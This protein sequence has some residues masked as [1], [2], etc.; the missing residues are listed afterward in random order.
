MKRF[1]Y[2]RADTPIQAATSASPKEAAFIAGGTNLLDLMKYEIETPIKLVDVTRLELEQIEPT[3]DGG[4]RIGTLVTNSDLAAHPDIVANYPVL[5]RAILAGATGQLRN[6]ATTGGNFLQRTRCYYFYQTDSPCNKRE[7]GTGCPAINGENRTLAILGTSEAC[8]AQHPSDMAVAMRL[9]DAK[10]ETVKTDG[11]TRTIPI[12]DFYC[13]PKDT[14]HIENVLESGELITHVVL[15]APIKG[16]HTYDKVR[17]RASYA[18]ALVSCAAVIDVDDSGKLTTIRLAFGGIG[19]EPWRNEKVEAL[20]TDTDGN[21]DVIRQAADL[22]LKEAKGNGQND[23]K[24]PLTRRLL[25]QVIQRAL[26][27]EGA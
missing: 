9:L 6:K 23:F 18:F 7:P 20:L 12:K 11:S 25:K 17:D 22:L 1:E 24:I 8:I 21:T 5:S 13:L 10:I 4:L 2:S 27:G 16:I 3:A 19:T 15:P 14:P 26:A